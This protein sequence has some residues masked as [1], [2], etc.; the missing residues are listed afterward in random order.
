V[1]LRIL[2]AQRRRKHQVQTQLEGVVD[3]SGDDALEGG[4]A[5]LEA[6][7]GVDLDEPGLEVL[8]DH[9]VEPEDFEGRLAG[10]LPE[11]VVGSLD[12]I[13]GYPFE[14]RTYVFHQ[15]L[16]SLLGVVEILLEVV[17]AKL[18][19]ILVLAVLV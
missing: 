11:Q 19:A 1:L 2:P 3:H 8:V 4:G 5:G 13:G 18:V 6:G 14:L 10:P 15:T 17:V 9:E 12:G 7:V 16:A